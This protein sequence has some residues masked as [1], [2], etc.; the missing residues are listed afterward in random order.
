M[1]Q[2]SITL[3]DVG[4]R[5]GFQSIGPV[6]PTQDKLAILRGLHDAGIRRVEA[7]AF[8]SERAVPQLADAA[9]VLAFAKS[10]P[11]MD[12]QVLVPS[13]RHAER[14]IA[15]GADHVAFVLSVSEK[16][17]MGNVRRTPG[18]SA[19]EY[20]RIVAGL[21]EGVRIRL[22]VAT[23]FDC[24]FDGAVDPAQTLEL[25][26]R[27]VPIAPHAEICLC[28]TTGCSIST[29]IWCTK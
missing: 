29:A 20:R 6:I 10:L 27:L 21:S 15:A 1:T 17:N 7:T 9:E 22:N 16:H 26:D 24:P 8:V 14:A 3:V 13:E 5:D 4:P 19:E 2:Q 18:E 12:A 25:L 11:G 28:D 23:A